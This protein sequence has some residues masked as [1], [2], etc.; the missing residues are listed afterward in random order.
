MLKH[1]GLNGA[2]QDP[3]RRELAA[4]PQGEISLEIKGL[5]EELDA[6]E[7]VAEQLIE[8][9]DSVLLPTSDEPKEGIDK[10]EPASQLGV[11]LH[12]RAQQAHGVY[13]R[14]ADACARLAL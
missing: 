5:A 3:S 2:L 1:Q 4:I 14:L 13:L 6:V 7:K 10:T 11:K 12:E 8:T 9:L